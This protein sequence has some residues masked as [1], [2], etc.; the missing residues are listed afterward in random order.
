[1]QNKEVR[2]SNYILKQYWKLPKFPRPQKHPSVTYHVTLQCH[3]SP[4][5][6]GVDEKH[7]HDVSFLFF[8]C[9][10]VLLV[11]LYLSNNETFPLRTIR[12]NDPTLLMM[13]IMALKNTLHKGGQF[14]E[15]RESDSMLTVKLRRVESK[16][17]IN[18]GCSN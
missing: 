9:L 8:F 15:Q 14:Q 2:S 12:K 4:S 16:K 6:L 3:V 11:S 7:L 10:F 13:M 17:E 18:G 1:M 5:P